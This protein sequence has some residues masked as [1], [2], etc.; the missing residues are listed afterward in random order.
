MKIE[1]EKEVRENNMIVLSRVRHTGVLFCLQ[2]LK[3]VVMIGEG[4]R[5][6][7]RSGRSVHPNGAQSD[8]AAK[9]P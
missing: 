6:Q 5:I 9:S 3:S 8:R 7:E 4:N 2:G 1:R